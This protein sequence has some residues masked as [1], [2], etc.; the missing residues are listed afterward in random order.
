QRY[1]SSF[2]SRYVKLRLINQFMNRL[3]DQESFV[4]VQA[5]Q[6]FIVTCLF[7]VV[8]LNQML[9]AFVIIAGAVILVA[10]CSIVNLLLPYVVNLHLRSARFLRMWGTFVS[11]NKYLRKKQM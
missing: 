8:K 9:P 6:T 10:I 5:G 3:V 1:E 4:L 2:F 7:A 11:R